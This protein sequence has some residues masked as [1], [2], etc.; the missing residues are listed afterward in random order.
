M[1]KERWR[2][3]GPRRDK[4]TPVSRDNEDMGRLATSDTWTK[5]PFSDSI[6]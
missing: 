5:D 3:P 2:S 4:G 6:D 1:S